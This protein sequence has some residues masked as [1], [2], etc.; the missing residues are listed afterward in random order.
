M[1]NGII[2]YGE[3]FVDYISVDSSNQNFQ[4]YIGG[5]TLNV[6]VGVRRLGSPSYYLCKLGEDEVSF[7]IKNE[8]NKEDVNLEY[9]VESGQKKICGVYVHLNDDGERYF[10]SYENES[11]DEQLLVSEL[12]EELFR[13]AKLFYF[14]SGTLFHEISRQTTKAAVEL[15][16]KHGT[17]VAF[18]PNIRMKR[19]ESEQKCRAAIME[20]LPNVDLLKIAE[21]ELLFLTE[22]L[23]VE[24]GLKQLADYGIPYVWVTLGEKGALAVH[25][26]VELHVPA[27]KVKAVDTT[28]A[29]DAFMAGI[30][31]CIH[32]KGLPEDSAALK[33]YTEYG[34]DLGG[35]AASVVGA[36]TVSKELF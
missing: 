17:L 36:L 10:H 7:F 19:W 16:Q 11:P 30:L 20:M 14:G 34:N 5:T 8:L 26:G 22:T 3:A 24:D 25:G 27:M 21:E 18:D 2:S 9:S 1:K 6:A 33:R 28:G 13:K 31:H 23:T 15:A 32:S 35:K 29:G 12:H 4:K